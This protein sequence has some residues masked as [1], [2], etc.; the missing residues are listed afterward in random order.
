M[1]GALIDNLARRVA[2]L[3]F[4]DRKDGRLALRLNLPNRTGAANGGNQDETH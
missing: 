1:V 3:D 2:I 4:R